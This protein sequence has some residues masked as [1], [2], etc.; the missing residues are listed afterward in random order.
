MESAGFV[1]EF[2]DFWND[3]AG[4]GEPGFT[5]SRDGFCRGRAGITGMDYRI[6]GKC[7]G[8]LLS[9]FPIIMCSIFPWRCRRPCDPAD[10]SESSSASDCRF[11]TGAGLRPLRR[12][13]GQ[14]FG[15]GM[16]RGKTAGG[17]SGR[18]HHFLWTGTS[19]PQLIGIS[20]DSRVGRLALL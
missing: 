12:P 18:N 3:P 10:D 16:D 4:T 8:N 1:W 11:Q 14:V 15:L 7:H 6:C 13:I 2:D 19:F 17:W 5:G 9:I 20:K